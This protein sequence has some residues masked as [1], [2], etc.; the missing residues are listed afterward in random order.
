LKKKKRKEKNSTTWQQDKD[1]IKKCPAWPLY[2]QTPLPTGSD[3]RG[4]KGNE[5]WQMDVFYFAEFGKV[6]TL[7]H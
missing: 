2:N 3:P 4:T 7:Y 6:C 1:M 5:I